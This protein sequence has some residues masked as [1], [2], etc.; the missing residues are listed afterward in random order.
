MK[1]FAFLVIA[2]VMT[3]VFG[4]QAKAQRVVYDPQEYTATAVQGPYCNGVLGGDVTVIAQGS[5]AVIMANG[6]AHRAVQSNDFALQVGATMAAQ[7]AQPFV[8]CIPGS[9]CQ[10]GYAVAVQPAR[11]APVFVHRQAPCL[12][13]PPA[14]NYMVFPAGPTVV[15]PPGVI[16][17]NNAPVQ[18]SPPITQ[19]QG[20]QTSANWNAPQQTGSPVNQG[21]GGQGQ[22]QAAG[23]PCPGCPQC[24]QPQPQPAPQ[25]PVQQ[26][27]LPALQPGV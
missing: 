25:A 6:L 23:H 20:G 24:A 12:P 9:R 14:P 21:Q 1:N 10:P 5:N 18:N 7:A 27:Q 4:V 8:M 11:Q 15:L 17:N 26:Q 13:A 22:L 2:V 19:T 3:A 16:F